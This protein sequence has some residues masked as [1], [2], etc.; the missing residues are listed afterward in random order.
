ML[1]ARRTDP[2]RASEGRNQPS[3]PSQSIRWSTVQSGVNPCEDGSLHEQLEK[4][5]NSLK[6]PGLI[7][8]W[9]VDKAL[10]GADRN[11]EIERNFNAAQIILLL[12]SVDFFASEHCND[13]MMR[14]LQ[15]QKEGHIRVIPI[16]L[17]TVDWENSPVSGLQPLPS[18]GLFVTQWVNSD[19]AFSH[20][21]KEIRKIVATLL[22]LPADI[23]PITETHLSYLH[24]LIKRPFYLDT[25]GINST[26]RFL[27]IQ[28]DEVYI[29]L[30]ARGEKGYQIARPALSL[31]ALAEEMSEQ[32]QAL[33]SLP[34]SQV[35]FSHDHLTILVLQL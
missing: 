18:D 7:S 20:I 15:R 6:R 33:P 9:S 13:V 35:M 22:N 31:Q 17:R 10:A 11:V 2:S 5:L 28:L 23:R 14:A 21:A 1:P 25:R 34:L 3:S 29:P 8:L 30:Q 24:W 4:H 16:L 26:Q 12:L 19:D 27:K 32:A